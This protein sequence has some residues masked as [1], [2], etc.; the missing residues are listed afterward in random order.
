[1]A[2]NLFE[3]SLRLLSAPSDGSIRGLLRALPGHQEAPAVEPGDA[4]E[5]SGSVATEAAIAATPVRETHAAGEG[6]L[7]DRLQNPRELSNRIAMGRALWRDLVIG[8][9]AQLG[10]LK[11]GFT[12]LAALYVLA[13]GST[14]TVADLADALNRSP[15]TVSRLVAGLV[16]R[17]FVERRPE[18]ADRRQVTLWLTTQGQALL[19]IVD[20][21]RADQFLA[22]VRPLPPHE[23]A[24]VAVGVAALADRIVTRR[25]RLI[26]HS[27]V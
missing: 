22:V 11:L 26:K 19:N 24:L 2:A 18:P 4:V 23:R 20:R 17:G 27:A 12:Q 16:K 9:A 15:S 3:D 5:A 8:F 1:M 21:A 10:E 6:T 7:I 14:T 13:D 25:G